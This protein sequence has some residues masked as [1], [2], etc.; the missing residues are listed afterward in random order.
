MRLNTTITTRCPLRSA[1]RDE[2][3]A[4]PC[5]QAAAPCIQAAAPCV[6]AATQGIQPVVQRI[7]VQLHSYLLDLDWVL[8]ACPA[9]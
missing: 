3:A 6:Q 5:T 7:Q 4:T 8:E 2:E 9:P 1:V